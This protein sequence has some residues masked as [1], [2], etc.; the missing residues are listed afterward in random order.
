MD[1]IMITRKIA[2]LCLGL[3]TVALLTACAEKMED[4][5]GH[6][7]DPYENT[8]R[9]IFNANNYLDR[10]ALKP[11][12]I[13]YRDNIPEPVRTGVHNA[14]TNLQTPVVFANELLQADFTGAG[15]SFS[16]FMINSTVGLGGL[17]DAGSKAG[18]TPQDTGFG[19]TLAVYGIGH[20]PYLVLPFVGPSTPREAVGFAGDSVSDPLTFFIPF[21]GD[22][23][24]GGV[25]TIDERS[26]YISETDA[27]EKGSVDE[28]AALRSIYF[29]QLEASDRGSSDKNA[30]TADIPDYA[31]PSGATAPAGGGNTH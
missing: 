7:Y 23:I 13:E 25:E 9:A 11:A 21:Y 8:N 24:E 30:G 16:R 29:Q 18:L 12:A 27:L 5:D 22:V 2:S 3:L 19:H 31:D 6:P 1:R 4:A 20:G 26:R 14:F 28:Y 15:T 10:N 17:L